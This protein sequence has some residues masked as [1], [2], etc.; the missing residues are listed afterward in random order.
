MQMNKFGNIDILLGSCNVSTIKDGRGG[1]FTWL[2]DKPILEFSMVHFLPGAVRGNHSHP[3]FD[4]YVLVVDGTVAIVTKNPVDNSDIA[5]V[6]SKGTCI[7]TPSGVSHAVHSLTEATYISFLTKP[8]D[9][10]DKPIIR[11]D[12]LPQSDSY[13]QYAKEQ[14]FKHSAEEIR[15]KKT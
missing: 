10:C 7:R 3:E 8:W 1:I 5:M 13:R 4:E 14:G 12:I 2:P 9:E 15:E 6:A 11:E